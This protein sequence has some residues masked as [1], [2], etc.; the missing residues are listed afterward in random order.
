MPIETLCAAYCAV[1]DYALAKRVTNLIMRPGV[2]E[3]KIDAHWWIA[4]NPH[5]ETLKT[6]TGA[7]VQFGELYIEFNGWPAGI[8]T[9]HG[10]PMCAGQI[11]NED[12]F[13]AAV[14]AATRKFE[15]RRA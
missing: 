14:Q 15:K 6:S 13:I 3:D 9:P 11:A 5:H 1:V 4:V 10:G 8:I 12:A 2:W 7:S